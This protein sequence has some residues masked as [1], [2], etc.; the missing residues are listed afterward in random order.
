MQELWSDRLY[1]SDIG[2]CLIGFSCSYWQKDAIKNADIFI[3]LAREWTN[4]HGKT[5]GEILG[6]EAG[7]ILHPLPASGRQRLTFI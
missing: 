7:H 1:G 3:I 5:H 6:A 4:P 2:H